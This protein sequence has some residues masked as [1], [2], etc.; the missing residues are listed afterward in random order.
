[1]AEAALASGLDALGFSGHSY[2]FFDESWCMSP[3]GT[4]EYRREIEA[5]REAYAGKLEILCG[6]EQD[7]YSLESTAGYDY[8]IGS[9]HYVWGGGAFLPVDE[10]PE[11]LRAGAEKAFGGDIYAFAEAYFDTV[12]RITEI[13]GCRVV[14]H[15]DLIAKFNEQ[16]PLFDEGHPRYIAAWQAAAE[17]LL[18]SGLP[19]EL[20]TGAIARGYRSVPY[21][22]PPILRYLAERG[23]RFLLSSDSHRPET[24]CFGFDRWR[25]ELLSLGGKLA[26]RPPT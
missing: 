1:M 5:L 11:H 16:E 25:R 3:A 8:V 23:A 10:S 26:D 20:N 2:T 21:P 14:G 19:F 4:A 7:Y 22:A 6:V 9:V 18:N 15:F 24:L 13:P 12:S 17:K